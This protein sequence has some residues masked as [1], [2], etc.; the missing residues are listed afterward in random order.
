YCDDCVYLAKTYKARPEDDPVVK[1]RPRDDR[2]I[3]SAVE[4]NGSISAE[5]VVVTAL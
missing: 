2:F 1:I 4:T 5:E 3:F